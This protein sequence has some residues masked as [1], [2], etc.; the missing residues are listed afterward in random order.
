MG[1]IITFRRRIGFRI[2]IQRIIGA[3]LHTGFTSDTAVTIKIHNTIRPSM[4]RGCG[5]NFYTG[6]IGTMVTPVDRKFPSVVRK[7]TLF[8]IFHMGAIHTK[9][10]IVLTFASNGTG[11]TANA[12]SVIYYKSVIHF[13]L[14]SATESRSIT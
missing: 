11:M 6:C 13:I 14:Y 10:H 4:K 2:D 9:G 3:S 7:F 8:D 1:A 5:A 12:H